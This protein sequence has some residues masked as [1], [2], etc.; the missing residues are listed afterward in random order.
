[1]LG[2]AL[3]M[4]GGLFL[5]GIFF[6]L[7]VEPSVSWEIAGSSVPVG[8]AL[9]G[10]GQMAWWAGIGILTPLAFS[11]IADISE[12]HFLRHGKQKDGSY[13]AAFT[14]VQK[15]ATSVGML[16]AG[17]MIHASGI[18]TGTLTQTPE[19]VRSVTML[20][21]LVGPAFLGVAFFV[22]RRYPVDRGF[23]A[24]ARGS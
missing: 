22:L 21:F 16:F 13:A 5:E 9:F 17:W 2:L 20:T 3:A 7:H 12:V 14:F 24:R 8:I 15:I 6:G 1:M 19:A 11:M 18:V 10:L 23:L 4:G